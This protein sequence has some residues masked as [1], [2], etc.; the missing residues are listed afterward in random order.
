MWWRS[1]SAGAGVGESARERGGWRWA[2][3]GCAAARLGLGGGAR[4]VVE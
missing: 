2:R 4:G 3:G 1:M